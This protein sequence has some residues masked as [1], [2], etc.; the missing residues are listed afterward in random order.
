MYVMYLA[1]SLPYHKNV[2]ELS[3]LLQDA[4]LY[5]IEFSQKRDV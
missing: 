4:V 5:V 2:E 1:T 3:N